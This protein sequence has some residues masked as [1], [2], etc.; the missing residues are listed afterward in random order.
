MPGDLFSRLVPNKEH[1]PFY[2][3]L[4]DDAD[5]E[6]RAVSDLDEENLAHTF[7]DDDLAHGLDDSRISSKSPD[8]SAGEARGRVP[9]TGQH[10][11]SRWLLNDDDGDNDVPASLLVEGRDP[12]W[13]PSL[14][15]DIYRNKASSARASRGLG[16][17]LGVIIG[18][19]ALTESHGYTDQVFENG[20]WNNRNWMPQ[21]DRSPMR[22]PLD[23]RGVVVSIFLDTYENPDGSTRDAIRA[24]ENGVVV[25]E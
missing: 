6:H 3:P 21:R 24:F 8:E 18:Q 10:P 2:Q 20:W 17:E 1:R 19:M 25:R 4:R 9:K 13:I 11:E 14:V 5:V 22:D 12:S 16:G 15:P 7:H 23:I